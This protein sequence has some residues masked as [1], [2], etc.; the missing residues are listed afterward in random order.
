M[1][2]D[3]GS[4]LKLAAHAHA[5]VMFMAKFLARARWRAIAT[6]RTQAR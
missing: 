3:E 4:A 5:L 6:P 1:H 2:E